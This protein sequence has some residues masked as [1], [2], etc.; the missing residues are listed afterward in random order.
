MVFKSR[1]A[2]LRQTLVWYIGE[3]I[4]SIININNAIKEPICGYQDYKTNQIVIS[5]G[6]EKA[7]ESL[8]TQVI[9]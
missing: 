6:H 3:C 8:H 2:R 4:V 7:R 1:I 5:S 9:I